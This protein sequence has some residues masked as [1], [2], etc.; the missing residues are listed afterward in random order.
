MLVVSHE[1]EAYNWGLNFDH[2]AA[3]HGV[4]MQDLYRMLMSRWP[5]P[6]IAV[7]W[8]GLITHRSNTELVR[9]MGEQDLNMAPQMHQSR[10]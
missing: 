9:I 4:P 5:Q 8:K 3:I 1:G 6:Y 2:M 10:M 7:F